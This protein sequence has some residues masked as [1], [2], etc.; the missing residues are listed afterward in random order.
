MKKRVI[1]AL[2]TALMVTGLV[3]G[4]GDKGGDA[5]TDANTPAPDAGTTAPA[6]EDAAGGDD[7]ETPDEGADAGD[8]AGA[9]DFSGEDPQ[10]AKKVKILTIW[11]EDNDNGILLNK[12]CENYKNDVNPNFEW[13]YEMVAADQLQ[14]KIATLAASNDLP[15]FFAYEAGAPLVTLIEADKIVNESEALEEIGATQYLNEGAVELRKGLSGTD[16]LR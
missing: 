8:A 10:L 5:G 9:T 11:A 16:D 15:D 13:E 6:T 2:L 7:A 14:Q 1:A 3:A 12:I 4:C